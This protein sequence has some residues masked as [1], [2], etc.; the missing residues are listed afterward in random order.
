VTSSGGT[1][2]VLSVNWL[3]PSL[4]DSR[5]AVWTAREGALAA[6][7]AALFC[8][9]DAHG[10]PLY[11]GAAAG[12]AVLA[13]AIWRLSLVAAVLGLLLC[14]ANLLAGVIYSVQLGEAEYQAFPKILWVVNGVLALGFVNAIRGIRWIKSRNATA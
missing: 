7:A 5:V 6:A 11:L 2:R 13:F 12:F 1:P 9:L 4:G 14:I 8:L 3:W 10:E